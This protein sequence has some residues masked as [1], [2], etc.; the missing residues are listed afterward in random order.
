MTH[1]SQDVDPLFRVVSGQLHVGH[2]D[3][4]LLGA[5][6]PLTHGSHAPMPTPFDFPAGHAS[7]ELAPVALLE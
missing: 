1:A 3:E 6:V 2:E 5:Y 4:P 7:H